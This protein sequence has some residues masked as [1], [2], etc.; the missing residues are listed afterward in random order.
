MSLVLVELPEVR[1]CGVK[2]AGTPPTT[3]LAEDLSYQPA[4]LVVNEPTAAM[5]GL[6]WTHIGRA[7]DLVDG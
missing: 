2:Q 5:L 7:D 3:F 4:F 1:L 6:L